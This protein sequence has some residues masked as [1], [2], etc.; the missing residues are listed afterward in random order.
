MNPT[1]PVDYGP[2]S[3][4]IGVWQGAR[5]MDVAP[6][7]DGAEHNPYYETITFTPAGDVTNANEQVLTAVR[8]H[9]VVSRV[10][11]NQVFHDETGYWIWDSVRSVIMHSLTIPRGVCLLAGGSYQAQ[12][13]ASVIVLEVAASIDD[14]DW[15]IVEAPYMRDHAST[16]AFK[17][18]LRLEGDKL[19]YFETTLVDIYGKTFE[20]TDQNELTRIG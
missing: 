11:N 13:D 7:P 18:R 19:S 16:R 15:K 20:H 6:E 14:R 5:G 10:T 2:L 3:G 17:Q 12:A 4:L 9:Q 8:Y 1:E